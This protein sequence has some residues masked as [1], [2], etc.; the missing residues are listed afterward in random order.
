MRTILGSRFRI[1]KKHISMRFCQK[2][3][4]KNMVLVFPPYRLKN[5]TVDIFNHFDGKRTLQASEWY[6]RYLVSLNSK[7]VFLGKR[8]K[9]NEKNQF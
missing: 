2:T 3:F 1:F 4:T 6:P 7:Y 8:K 5:A 9:M